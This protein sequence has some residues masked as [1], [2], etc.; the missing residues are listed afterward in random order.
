MLF[1]TGDKV[2]FMNKVGGGYVT[3]VL[4]N[5]MVKVIIEGGLEYPVLESELILVNPKSG[6][7]KYFDEHYDINMPKDGGKLIAGKKHGKPVEKALPE[8]FEIDKAI[9]ERDSTKEKISGMLNLV[10][11]GA[12]D[13]VEKGVYLAYFPVDETKLKDTDLI[14]SI[15]NYTT[16]DIYVNIYMN[17]S[18]REYEGYDLLSIPAMKRY[19]ICRIKRSE[20]S[21]W[22]HGVFQVMFHTEKTKMVPNPVNMEVKLKLTHFDINDNFRLVHIDSSRV[23]LVQLNDIYYNEK[24][25]VPK[26]E[27]LKD[28][29]IAEEKMQLSMEPVPTMLIDRHAIGKGRVKAEVDLHISSLR[30]DFSEMKNHEILQEQVRYFRDALESAIEAHYKT[31]VFIHG[32]GNGTL[33]TKLSDILQ[34]EYPDIWFH[35]APFDKYGN[36]ALELFIS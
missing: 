14:V 15:V 9:A 33:K 28:D 5:N 7:E 22:I 23:F 27:K 16:Y 6:L 3:E 30:K 21:H 10:E 19:N 17:R 20:L 13:V 32:I 29:I 36:G 34:A 8:R 2:K 1:K 18:M 35:N 24:L 25:N 11:N 26:E 31:V 4:D 12:G